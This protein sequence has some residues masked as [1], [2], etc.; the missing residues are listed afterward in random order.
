VE[1]TNAS[2]GAHGAA[3]DL[4]VIPAHDRRRAAARN[5][6]VVAM[7]RSARCATPQRADGDV[8]ARRR[9]AG[10]FPTL[11]QLVRL[12]PPMGGPQIRSDKK[13]VEEDEHWEKAAGMARTGDWDERTGVTTCS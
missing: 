3:V 5:C 13:I 10:A 8:A 6:H 4:A 12:P 2:S 11:L 1:R 9:L 7:C